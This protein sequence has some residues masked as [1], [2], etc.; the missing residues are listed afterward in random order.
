MR[1]WERCFS[2]NNSHDES[3][4]SNVWQSVD[5]SIQTQDRISPAPLDYLRGF[6]AAVPMAYK[7]AITTACDLKKGDSILDIGCGTATQVPDYLQKIGMTGRYV[8][9]DTS[10]K[11]IE[12]ARSQHDGLDASFQ[13]A[14]VYNRPFPSGTFDCVKEDRV[15]EH[16]V[17][18]LE[19]V[20]EMIRVT[21]PGGLIV[22]ANPDFRTFVLDVTGAGQAAPGP[23][24]A[25]RRWG[26]SQ[27]PPPQLDFDMG[28]LTMRLLNGVIP[29]LTAHSYIGTA[30]PR[31]LRAAGAQR[32]QLDVV[33]VT[34][35]GRANLEAVVPITYMAQLSVNNG[36]VSV[37]EKEAWLQRLEWEGHDALLGTLNF[38]ICRGIKPSEQS[39]FGGVEKNVKRDVRVCVATYQ[40]GYRAAPRGYGFDQQ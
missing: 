33:P 32:I 1:F 15:F 16:L 29:T 19:A 24:E 37:E 27:R 9:I 31:L 38:Y 30:L 25:G 35:Q 17:R 13:V 23:A 10:E 40:D 14:D 21:K 22:T 8:G 28:N 3:T 4:Y 6:D 2:T 20:Q 39:V 26:Q 7:E 11:I 34:L 36:G 5:S 18:P 12:E